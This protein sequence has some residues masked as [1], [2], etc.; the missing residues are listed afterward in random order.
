[1]IEL[2]EAEVTE[3]HAATA[4]IP[5]TPFRARANQPFPE[6]TLIGEKVVVLIVESNGTIASIK[7]V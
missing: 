1:M 2:A 6:A 7:T 5:K 3:T 4:P